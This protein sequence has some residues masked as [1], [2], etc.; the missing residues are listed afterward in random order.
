[1]STASDGS[2]GAQGKS[3]RDNRWM[4]GEHIQIC[5]VLMPV[6]SELSKLLLDIQLT[7]NSTLR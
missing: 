3:P 5:I 7:Y 1:M 4:E 6:E 2:R